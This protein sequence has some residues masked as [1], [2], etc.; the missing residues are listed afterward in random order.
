TEVKIDTLIAGVVDMVRFMLDGK[1]CK[2]QVKLPKDLPAVNADENR[3]IQVLF[4][5]L[6]NA[7][8]FTDDGTITVYA[9]YQN[10]MARIHVKDTGIGI[11]EEEIGTI[12]EP[13]EQTDMNAARES[14]G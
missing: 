5:L 11:K 7:V 4:N 10:K 6:H 12:F 9:D 14:G 13:Y 3:I 2:L 8:K 1:P